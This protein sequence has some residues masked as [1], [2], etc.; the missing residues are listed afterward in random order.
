MFIQIDPHSGVP[1]Y[2]QVMGQIRYSVA[3]GAS[4]PGSQI[5]SVRALAEQLG[6]NP[7]TIM[8][9]YTELEREGLLQTLR[10]QGTFVA[11]GGAKPGKRERKALLEPHLERFLSGAAQLGLDKKEME[12][13]FRHTLQSFME[14][15]GGRRGQSSD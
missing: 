10:G 7:M 11:K 6:V 1:I 5:P 4:A 14:R 15:R 8:K 3:T 13:L 2:M 9:A 12:E